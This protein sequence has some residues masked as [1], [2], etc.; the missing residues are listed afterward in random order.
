MGASAVLV[1]ACLLL[2]S[3]RNICYLIIPLICFIVAILQRFP[4]ISYERQNQRQMHKKVSI[5]VENVLIA[6]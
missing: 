3:L 4:P 5:R 6:M 2:R 1:V